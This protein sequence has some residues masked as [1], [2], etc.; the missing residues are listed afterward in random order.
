MSI[1]GSWLLFPLERSPEGWRLKSRLAKCPSCVLLLCCHSLEALSFP[2]TPQFHFLFPIR[3]SAVFL[4]NVSARS[5]IVYFL[6]LIV[7]CWLLRYH[8]AFFLLL[9]CTFLSP[10]HT[11]SSESL[12]SFPGTSQICRLSPHI[13]I[14]HTTSFLCLHNPGAAIRWGK[15]W[16]ELICLGE[17]YSVY[18]PGR[19]QLCF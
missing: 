6:F 1:N 18:F 11:L 7:S 19:E 5:K 10:Q 12:D 4:A 2:Y 15:I 14:P 17:G 13:P 16:V 8:F 9:S 3:F